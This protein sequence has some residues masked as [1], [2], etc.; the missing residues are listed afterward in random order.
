HCI[1][2]I[3]KRPDQQPGQEKS[4][5]GMPPG[6]FDL[7]KAPLDDRA[8]Y[9]LLQS[10]D[11][12]GVFQLESSGMQQ[13]FRDL[14]PD[15]FED[16]VAAVALYR[17]GPLETGMVK[18]FVE[19]KHGRQ[20]IKKMHALIDDLLKPTYGVIVYQEQVMQIAQGLAGYS[21]G[22]ADLLRRA[23]GKKKPEE[24]AK[25]KGTFVDG[26]V[27]KGVV[28]EEASAIFDLV[29]KFA[30]YGFN[31][32][33][34]AAYALITYQT[35]WLKAHYPV[36]FLCALMTA[37]KEKNDKVVRILSEAQA[38]NIKVLP[39]DIN[40][41][42][43]DFKV[44]YANPNGDWKQHSKFKWRDPYQPQIRF[45]LGAV[46]GVGGSALDAVYEA[47]SQGGT[48]K[49]LFD[50][51]ARVDAKRLNRAVLE[52][53]V[54]CGAFDTSLVHDGV[55]RARAYAGID[56]ALERARSAS[57]D[58]ERGQT[59]LFGLFSAAEATSGPP[60]SEYPQAEPWDFRETLAREK[61]AL[62]YYV[63]G[64][65]LDRYGVD[66]SRFE[67]LKTSELS[68]RKDWEVVRIAGMV[69]GYREKIF[70][71]GGGRV[72]FFDVED[73]SG[74]ASVKVRE[75]QIA[76]FA[77]QITS[78]EPVIVVGKLQFPQSSDESE[79]A[80]QGP[81]EPTVLLNEVIPLSDALRKQVR[82]VTLKLS[83][84]RVK[85]EQLKAL[86][87]VLLANPGPCSVSVVLKLSA[88]TEVV[89]GVPSSVEVCDK[90]L[91]G[92]ERLFG[93]KIA[94]LR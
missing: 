39:P 65:P 7:D 40:E 38:W 81:R 54:Q 89:L 36:E 88:K 78:G 33:H 46:R 11:T 43:T 86:N 72:A 66:M 44:V 4:R 71:G 8:T 12:T 79:D 90:M 20:P 29:E 14:K 56:L 83:A 74:R 25:Q 57:K 42:D 35:A 91:A 32:S 24:M 47:R 18:D 63:S 76:E 6:P 34:S 31:K 15:C 52:A 60:K 51:A 48:F 45:G 5:G 27:G 19:C 58:R 9:Q 85:R 64:H 10:G 26:A 67:V 61:Q 28:A 70:K 84:D 68:G 23:M 75:K 82:N 92:I 1:N 17:P 73:V 50:F 87:D 37:D 77:T 94:E 30:G 41:S 21:L 69:E 59:S 3:R 16:I 13:L 80:D 2:A 62:G 55:S 49:G 93:T 53:L 22:G